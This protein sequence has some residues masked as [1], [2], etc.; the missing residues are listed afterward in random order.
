MGAL[1]ST[2][3]NQQQQDEHHHDGADAFDDN[4]EDI[5]QL[6]LDAGNTMWSTEQ[7]ISATVARIIEIEDSLDKLDDK[8]DALAQ[9]A[10]AQA[11]EIL[12]VDAAAVEAGEVN[13]DSLQARAR[14]LLWVCGDGEGTFKH[15]C[16]HLDALENHLHARLMKLQVKERV[17]SK[18][19]DECVE[20]AR[21]VD[22]RR[23]AR[24]RAQQAR[25]ITT[26]GTATVAAGNSGTEEQYATQHLVQVQPSGE[27]NVV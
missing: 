6:Q 10:E 19:L 20:M 22:D 18:D 1:S 16:R 25:S 7:M 8:R 14:M 9:Q 17:L 13:A 23:S 4:D 5:E 2:S 11:M 3:R 21:A 24:R 27:D 26:G 15:M 12:D